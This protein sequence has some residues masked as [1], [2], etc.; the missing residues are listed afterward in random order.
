MTTNPAVPY[1]HWVHTYYSDEGTEFFIAL[2]EKLEDF[3]R[4]A[5]AQTTDLPGLAYLYLKHGFDMD[6]WV[7][8]LILKR[9]E[10]EGILNDEIPEGD[11]DKAIRKY[12]KNA[13]GGKTFVN[14]LIS[15]KKYAYGGCTDDIHEGNIMY[16]PSNKKLVVIDPLADLNYASW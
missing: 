6:D 15:A 10:S 14:T 2:I 7:T 8:T 16:R 4:P 11:G 1:I 3:N 13:K 9:F 12:L 5:I